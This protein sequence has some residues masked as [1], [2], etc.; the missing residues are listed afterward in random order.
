MASKV[1]ES[2]SST[3]SQCTSVQG[4]TRVIENSDE[5]GTGVFLSSAMIYVTG[6]TGEKVL[7]I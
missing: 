2:E 4:F 6:H 3:S 1:S 5:G 7:E